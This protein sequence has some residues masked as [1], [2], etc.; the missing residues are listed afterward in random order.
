MAGSAPT[1]FD[2]TLPALDG[3]TL[4]LSAHRGKVL[5]LVNVASQCGYTPQYDALEHLWRSFR[6]RGL[7]VIGCPCNQFGHQEPGTAQEIEAFCETR[8]QISF[9][10]SDKLRV[11]G[12]EA[13]PLWQWLQR[14]KPGVLGTTAI[15][16]NFTKFLVNRDGRVVD[17]YAPAMNPAAIT[18]KIER[19]LG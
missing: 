3:S 19:L 9:P 18:G 1:C 11:N 15:K 13:H 8:Y 14:E 5:L 7:V 16:W 4:D 12:A 10:M 17:R 6:S 2:F